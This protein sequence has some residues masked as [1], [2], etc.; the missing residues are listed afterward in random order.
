MPYGHRLRPARAT[1]LPLLL[2]ARP[3]LDEARG[4]RRLARWMTEHRAGAAVTY[5]LVDTDETAVLGSVRV[6]ARGARWW[7]VPE[8]EG[9][10]LASS[11]PALAEGL[12]ACWPTCSGTQWG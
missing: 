8:C 3:D 10:D 4:R 2:V 7:V 5:L 1:D 9:T 6:T 12:A 11:L